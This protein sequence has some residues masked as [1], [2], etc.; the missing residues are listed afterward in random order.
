VP[1]EAAEVTKGP[2]TEQV[3]AVGANEDGAAFETT[4]P[5]DELQ[6]MVDKMLEDRGEDGSKAQ[7]SAA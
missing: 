7:L 2:L 4:R 5:Y 6:V 1:V 3:A